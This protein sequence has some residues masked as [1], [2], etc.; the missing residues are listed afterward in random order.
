MGI[1]NVTTTIKKTQANSVIER[2]HL[3]FGQILRSILAQ[4]K[5]S[6]NEQHADLLNSYVRRSILVYFLI[7]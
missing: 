6:N 7:L 5:L 2:M 4:A 3:S 1:A